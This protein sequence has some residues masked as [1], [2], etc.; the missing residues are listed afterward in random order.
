MK[1]FNGFSALLL[2]ALII[3]GTSCRNEESIFIGDPPEERLRADSN[4]ARLLMNIATKDGSDDNIID[5]ASCI[6]LKFPFAV[7]IGGL[8]IDVEG[9]EDFGTIETILYNDDND[10]VD[11]LVGDLVDVFDFDFDEDDNDDDGV[12]DRTLEIVFP[13]TVISVDFSQTIVNTASELQA[14]SALCGTGDDDDIECI[15]IQFPIT[16]TL[17]IQLVKSSIPLLLKATW[18]F[19]SS[20]ITWTPMMSSI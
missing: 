6:S 9:P 1:Q 18:S 20:W 4:I 12:D 16:V 8:G 19:I 17:L 7:K 13:V 3:L 10:L 15:D 2:L 5:R 11:D 14:F